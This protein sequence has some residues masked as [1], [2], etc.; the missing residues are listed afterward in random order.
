M[1]RGEEMNENKRPNN[2]K[3]PKDTSYISYGASIGLL[4]GVVLGLT[5]LDN[6]AVGLGIGMALGF[7]VGIVLDSKKRK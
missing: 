2:D 7:A 1:N 5:V 4:I 6:L 3:E